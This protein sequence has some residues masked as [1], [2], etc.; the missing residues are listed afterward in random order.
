VDGPSPTPGTSP[1]V[2]D[3]EPEGP[4]SCEFVRTPEPKGWREELFTTPQFGNSGPR[5]SEI[6]EMGLALMEFFGHHYPDISANFSW[7]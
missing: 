6:V 3:D 1:D 2:S 5:R 4:E 7:Y